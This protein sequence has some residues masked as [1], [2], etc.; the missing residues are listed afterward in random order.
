MSD[1]EHSLPPTNGSAFEIDG[2]W[3]ISPAGLLC[4]VAEEVGDSVRVVAAH[5]KG[6]PISPP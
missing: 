1:R 3:Y 5:H 4:Q 6:S 2:T